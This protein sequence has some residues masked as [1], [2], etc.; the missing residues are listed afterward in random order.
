MI[1]ELRWGERGLQRPGPLTWTVGSAQG[2]GREGWLQRGA[3]EQQEVAA[4]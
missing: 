3:Q 2:D 4:P 1:D